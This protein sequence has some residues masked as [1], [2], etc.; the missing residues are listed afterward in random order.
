M[1]HAVVREVGLVEAVRR[2]YEA[3]P[4]PHYPLLARPV[5][6]D[7]Y[8]ASASFAARLA[9]DVVGPAARARAGTG[10]RGRSTILLG[11]SGEILPYV[12]RKWEPASSAILC[13]DLSAT[14]LRR[15]RLRLLGT[16]KPTRFLRG[17]LD[18]F[19]AGAE[20]GPFDHVDAYGVL[21]HMPDPTRTL[22]HIAS[23]VVPGGTVRLM[24]YNSE[25]R[26]WIHALQRVFA[27]LRLDPFNAADRAEARALLALLQR[28]VPAIAE[29][30][31]GV[32]ATTIASDTRLV[33][34][35]L[36][37]REARI[38]PSAWLE[39]CAAV[40]L[41]PIALVD[42]YAE[43]DDLPNP[44]WR[45]PTPAQL[46]ERAADAR[47][48]NNLEL[49]LRKASPTDEAAPRAAPVDA[50][51]RPIWPML[52]R[53]A[54]RLWFGFEETRGIGLPLRMALWK[55]HLAH[56]FGS[57]TSGRLDEA[58][59]RN[60]THR[61]LQRLARVGAVLPGQLEDRARVKQLTL[62]MTASMT[63][64]HR[65]PAVDVAKIAPLVEAIEGAL[66]RRG[67]ADTRRVQA[68][69]QRIASAQ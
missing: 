53:R 69:L 36:H 17:D 11:G 66:A 6:Q 68:V 4:Y 46:A 18:T 22:A 28:Y 67:L 33:D 49:Y 54:P 20:A 65:P 55:A 63:P 41:A 34:T 7:G 62:P 10:P 61:A 45:A 57:G 2:L 13:L 58:L 38:A 23:R 21:H 59:L 42:R 39:R 30:L 14:S 29:R 24:V 56:V 16:L 43:L 48:E 31:V 25:A 1:S 35:F 51:S 47:F 15:A 27:L 3:F 64:P 19:L 9:R 26:R 50:P 12:V 40:G 32:G 8:L 60:L 5:W 44:L 52:L 37:A